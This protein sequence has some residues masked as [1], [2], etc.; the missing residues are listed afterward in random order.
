[1][2]ALI[3]LSVSSEIARNFLTQMDTRRGDEVPPGARMGSWRAVAAQ[4][5]A[6][7]Q[8]ECNRLYAKYPA[9]RP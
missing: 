4:R 5:N 8:A 7:I 1:L 9:V 3:A 6:R 2:G